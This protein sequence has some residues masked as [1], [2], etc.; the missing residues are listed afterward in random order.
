M[1]PLSIAAAL[2]VALV[3]ALAVAAPPPPPPPV[4][5]TPAPAKPQGSAP[6]TPARLELANAVVAQTTKSEVMVEGVMKGFEA[7]AKEQQAKFQEIDAVAPGLSAKMMDRARQEMVAVVLERLPDLRSRTARIYAENFTDDELR[8][9]QGFFASPTGQHFIRQMTTSTAG[10]DVGDNLELKPED[11]V[12]ANQAAATSALEGM[13]ADQQVDLVK[14]GWSAAGLKM[15]SIGPKIQAVSAEWMTGVLKEF[16]A[17]A[18]P[19]IEAMVT[20]ALAKQK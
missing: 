20:E 2:V 11:L 7:G 10:P 13:T 3:P 8:A 12:A 16:Q 6:V 4:V 1:R 15:R 9:M 5:I 19:I 17:R 18:E 14:F